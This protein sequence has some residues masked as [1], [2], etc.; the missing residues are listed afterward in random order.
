MVSVVI[1]VPCYNEEK[2]FDRA[3]FHAFKPPTHAIKFLFV[4]DGSTDNT[5][6]LLESLRMSNSDR[7]SVL[8][9][10]Q[11]EG[12][13]E[14][15]RQGIIR[16]LDSKPDY[17]GFWDADLATPLDTIPQFVDFAENRPELSMIIGARV[18]LLGREIQRKSS[19]HYLGRVFATAASAVLGLAVYDTQCGAKLFRVSPLVTDL[20]QH[21]FQSR[22][23]FDV[24]IIAR[25]IK[26][27]RGRDMLQADRAIYEFPLTEWRDVPASKV[28]C[29]DFMRAVWELYR[30]HKK[31]F[32][33][34]RDQSM[35]I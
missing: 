6:Q 9:L 33:D 34:S 27:G 22:W 12:K 20:F 17:V 24:E 31:Y 25:L 2:R 19:R 16:A 10:P 8:S 35:Q 3:S 28:G 14:A 18:K 30:I 13:A 23:I 4:N 15:V 26:Q 29:R 11:N 1:V 5:L 21:R 32:R 7:F